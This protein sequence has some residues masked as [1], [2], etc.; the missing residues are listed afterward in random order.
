LPLDKF[1]PIGYFSDASSGTIAF[2]EKLGEAFLVSVKEI[3][4]NKSNGEGADIS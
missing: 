1:S 3:W 4:Y 2:G